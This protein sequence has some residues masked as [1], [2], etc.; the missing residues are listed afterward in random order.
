VTSDAPPPAPRAPEGEELD[1]LVERIDK[2][3]AEAVTPL[4]VQ[5]AL[6]VTQDD[7]MTPLGAI[8]AAF[9]YYETHEQPRRGDYFGPISQVGDIRNPPPFDE[10]DPWVFETWECCADLV[11]QP[12]ALARLNDL[13]FEARRGNGRDRAGAAARAYLQAAE[14]FPSSDADESTRIQVG[15]GAVRAL[16]RALDLARAT[17]QTELAAEIVVALV[18]CAQRSFDSSDAGPGVVLGFIAPLVRHPDG[19]PELDDLLIRARD[20]YRDDMWNTRSTIELQLGRRGLSTGD[21][22]RLAREEVEAILAEAEKAPPMIKVVHLEDAAQ[23]AEARGLRDLHD[24][25]IRRLQA[26]RGTDLGMVRLQHEVSIPE[27]VVDDTINGIIGVS[28]WQQALVNLVSSEPPSGHLERNRANVIEM[29]AAAP[30]QHLFP[31]TRVG[32]DG[33]PRFTAQ[34]DAEREVYH[35]AE[36]E[37]HFMQ[38]LGGIY[39]TALVRL[40]QE[41]APIDVAELAKFLGAASHVPEETAAS[42]ARSFDRFFSGDYEGAFFTAVPKAERLARE[43]L[44]RMGMPVFNTARGATPGGYSGLGVLMAMLEERGFDPS[45]CRYITTLLSRQEG[46]NLRNESAHGSI[47]DA[48]ASFAGLVLIATL[49]LA[50]AVSAGSR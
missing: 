46:L 43:L 48:D 25:A 19:A 26:M 37:V 13:L 49:Y 33:L 36:T 24:E 12:V 38:V 18:A 14:A 27:E 39:V 30:L 17:G 45:W 34:T 2:A 44:L 23:L 3:A 5:A 9:L 7:A 31:V 50:I 35:L 10:L 42:L 4:D 6:G 29:K 22:E 15:L 28:T 47:D 32:K 40:G 21:R 1:A 11:I 41:F 20:R 8:S 16:A